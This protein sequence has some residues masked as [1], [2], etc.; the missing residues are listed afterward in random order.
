MSTRL[1]SIRNPKIYLIFGIAFL[2]VAFFYPNEMRFKYEYQRGR[3]W[4]YETLIAPMDFPILKTEA[5]LLA[6][7]ERRAAQVLP[8]FAYDRQT[9]PERMRALNAWMDSLA[10]DT[11]LKEAFTQAMAHMYEKGIMPAFEEES[12]KD[13]R[14]VVVERNRS[15]SEVPLGEVFTESTVPMYLRM[16]LSGTYPEAD[17]VIEDLVRRNLVRPNLIFDAKRTEMFH[18]NAV[19]YISPT[20]GMCYTG[21]LIVAEG[22]TVTA[23]VEQVL[24]SFKAEYESSF[25]YGGKTWPLQFGHGIIV[26]I[27]LFLLFVSLLFAPG[28]LY[29]SR[30]DFCFF[31]LQFVLA[32]LLTVFVRD[33]DPTFLYL[34]P[35]AVFALYIISFYSETVAF[36]VYAVILLPLLVIPENG[37][38]LFVMNLLA[39]SIGI[40][41][42]R[43]FNGGWLQFVNA[44]FIFCGIIAVYVTF[45]LIT[46]GSLQLFNYRVLLMLA[47]YCLLV[48]AAYPLVYVLEKIF[49]FVSDATLKELTDTNSKLLLELARK[50]PGT[51]QHS[52]QVANLADAAVREIGGN[53]LQVRAGAL[54]HDIGK[55]NNPQCFVENQN[56]TINYH[57]SLTPEESARQIIRHVDDG[58]EIARKHKLPSVV[59]DYIRTHHAQTVTAYFY[60]TY[61]NNGGD[62]ENREPFTYNGKL[63]V[64]KEQVIVLMA[65]AVEASSRSL[66]DYSAESI[67]SL[68]DKIIGTRLSDSQ[69]LNADISIKE[70][71]I[72]KTIFKQQLSQM[73]HAR[74]SYPERRK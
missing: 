55:M 64:T 42:F 54:Y 29:G 47:L 28:D 23:Q 72:V 43:R 60:N 24:D 26:L 70:I 20:K 53:V 10:L 4:L 48:V 38:E 33:F 63:P 7:R 8:V 61:C 46:E 12:E 31:V 65:D 13:I 37:L 14:M 44:F 58:L 1:K 40:L 50:A 49:G 52:L 18:K 19:D 45:R 68:V 73:Y 34:V 56:G 2:I 15:V 74:I 21:Q 25:A 30:Y 57:E 67:S 9:G 36:P 11:A 41:S 32:F 22:E 59:T 69:L 16:A 39:G 5:E 71:N 66:K 17:P 3:P 27:L 6:E 62:P 51:F 35:Y